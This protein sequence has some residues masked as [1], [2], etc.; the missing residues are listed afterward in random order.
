MS[1]L[2]I[3]SIFGIGLGAMMISSCS[4]LK[5]GG[6][7]VK[8]QAVLPQDREQIQKQASLKTYTPEELAKG[9]VKGDWAIEEVNGKKAVGE[10]APFL[11]FEPNSQKVYGNNGCNTLNADYKYNPKD[12][13]LTFSNVVTTMMACTMEGITDYEINTALNQTAF[14]RWQLGDNCYYL[15]LYSKDHQPLLTLMHQNFAFLNGTWRVVSI[16]DEPISV[17]DMKLVIDVDEGKLH[18]FTGCNII[19]GSLET[20]MDSPNSISFQEI[21]VTRMACPNDPGFETR[22][23]VALEDASRAKPIEAGKVLFLDDSNQVV[24]TLVRTS[25]K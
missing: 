1:L 3:L 22:L 17:P 10:T 11:K 18:G 24:L 9:T 7:K 5:P 14:Y 20:D 2:K 6:N 16:D 8:S 25:D 12:S 4:L 21:M 15:Y 13:V 19:N 23:L